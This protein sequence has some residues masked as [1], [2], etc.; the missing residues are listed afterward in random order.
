MTVVERETFDQ[1][2]SVCGLGFTNDEWAE[3]HTAPDLSP[4]HA[5]CCRW[6]PITPDDNWPGLETH[7]D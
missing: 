6:C 4:V 2:C 1:F 5:H 3:R 7:H